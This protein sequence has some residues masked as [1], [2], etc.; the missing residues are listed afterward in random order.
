MARAL[1]DSLFIYG[2]HDPGSEQIMLDAGVPGWVLVT[3]AIGS[4]PNDRS[5]QDY[6]RFSDRGLGVI[7]R[8]NNGYNPGGTLPYEREYPNFARRCGNFA[9][10][11][12]GAHLW[13]VGNETNHPIEWPGA[14]WQWGPGWPAPVSPDKRGE[15]ITPARYASCYKQ[16]RAAIRAVSGR[17]EDQVL[18]AGPAPWNTLLTYPGNPSGDWVKYFA[19]I[20]NAIG[21]GNLDGIVLHTYTH[22]ASPGPRDVR[23]E[24]VE[25]QL[26]QPPLPVP[27]LPGL[28]GRDPRGN[29]LA[30]RVHHRDQPG[31]RTLAEHEQRLGARRLRGDRRVEPGEQPE[32]PR[33]AAVPLAAGAGRPVGRRRQGRA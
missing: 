15:D 21:A 4:D 30:P 25:P 2:F 9:A 5:G 19:D 18:V 31:R 33:A 24:D 32:D 11:S 14:E 6:R 12:Q 3:E 16:C 22:G 1:N 17:G 29:A 8:L 23:R 7:V 10:A 13:I 26:H 20:L 28:H 27:H